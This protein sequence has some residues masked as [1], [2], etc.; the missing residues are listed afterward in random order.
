M[1]RFY[2]SSTLMW[3][4]DVRTITDMAYRNG[5]AG[6]ELWAQQAESKNWDLGLLKRLKEETGLDFLIH[7]KSWDLNYASL[8]KRIRD[9]SL[10]EIRASI[11]LAADLGAREV[12]VHPPRYTL[13]ECAAQ[14][15]LAYE[16]IHDFTDYAC[17]RGIEVSM[18]LM[19]HIPKEMATSPGE[20][21]SMV[22]DLDD[23]LSYTVDLAHCLSEREFFRNIAAM[24]RVSKVHLTN[25]QGK[26]LHTP[27]ADGDFCFEEI[28]PELLKWNLPMVI[29][30]YEEGNLFH[31]LVK[32]KKTIQSL[33][34]LKE[35]SDE[36]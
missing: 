36:K 21:L 20:M 22:R 5:F 31:A 9:A 28:Y 16:S 6:I 17:S 15:E 2:F 8:N 25:K 24:K 23:R 1:D 11:D 12:T 13:N 30:G 29:E 32:N 3:D 14:R 35:K 33:Q 10:E 7:A 4:A 34:N 19:E 27:L 18:E 26:K